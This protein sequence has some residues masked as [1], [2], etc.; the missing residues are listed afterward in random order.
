MNI[1]SKSAKKSKKTSTSDGDS[2]SRS[3]SPT[4]R[5]PFR[6][7]NKGSKD[8]KLRPVPGS[9][10]HSGSPT[11][12]KSFSPSFDPNSHPLN[13]PPDQLRRLS[14]LSSMTEQAPVDVDMDDV[15]ANA[16]PSSPTQ[17]PTSLANNVNGVTNGTAPTPPPHKS[18]PTSPAAPPPPTPEEAEAW[19]GAGNKYYKAREWKKAIQEYTKGTLTFYGTLEEVN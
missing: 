19:K 18:A 8:E 16:S 4:K 1:F 15:P 13:L 7:S 9:S 14:A 3:P 11:K 10:K 6:S 5:S 12:A 2:Q 17:S